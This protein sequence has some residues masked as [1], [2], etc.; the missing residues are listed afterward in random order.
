M[1]GAQVGDFGL[2]MTGPDGSH[3]IVPVDVSLSGASCLVVVGAANRPP[4]YRIDNR[5]G[6]RG[7]L[8]EAARPPAPPS[9]DRNPNCYSDFVSAACG[10]TSGNLFILFFYFYSP[11]CDRPQS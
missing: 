7:A 3:A 2:R 1:P 11:W 4:P 5:C 6:A 8:A 9:T 10:V